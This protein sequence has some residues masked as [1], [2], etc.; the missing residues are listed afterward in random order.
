MD[1]VTPAPLLSIVTVVKD[2]PEGLRLTL[3]SVLPHLDD[4]IQVTVI[5]GSW[6]AEEAPQI[7]SE[8]GG[9]AVDLC[10][11]APTGV[12]PA[13]NIGL[14]RARGEYVLFLNA[15]DELHEP[16]AL[17][18]VLATLEQRAPRWLVARVAF[19]DSGG[20]AVVPSQFDYE[21]ERRRRFTRGVFP[22]HQGT[23]VRRQDLLALRGFDESYRITADYKVALQLSTIDEPILSDVVLA[24]FHEGGVSGTQWQDSMK[25]FRRA[26]QEVY[27]LHGWLKM[28]DDVA[29]AVQYSKM[30]AARALG[31]V[32]T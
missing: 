20:R 12:Y 5:D 14:S 19:V 27:G 28:R 3:S 7:V 2:D 6:D 22:P 9:T 18:S 21:A 25:E 16:A 29:S 8:F 17:T 1:G 23:V 30:V 32:R 13:M 24:T 10:W 4:R 26:R 15:G 11:S 31:R